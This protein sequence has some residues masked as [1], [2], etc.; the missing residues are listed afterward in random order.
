MVCD[1]GAEG[2]PLD[3]IID[4]GVARCDEEDGC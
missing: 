4:V 2:E 1:D 3:C